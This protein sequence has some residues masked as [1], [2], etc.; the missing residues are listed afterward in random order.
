MSELFGID[1]AQEIADAF[2]G[3]LLTGSFVRTTT[4][5]RDPNNL[6]AGKAAGFS[7]THVFQGFSETRDAVYKAGSLVREAGET[8]SIFGA[9]VAPFVAPR[10]GDVVTFQGES[11]LTLV[12]LISRDPAS[13]LYTFSAKA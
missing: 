2:D 4:G 5:A 3:E 13:A 9:S 6:S 1:I 12:E 7:V 11:P 10:V 8:V